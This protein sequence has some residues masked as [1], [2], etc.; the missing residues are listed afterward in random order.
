V[1]GCTVNPQDMVAKAFL[2]TTASLQLS[3]LD[4][5]FRRC[6]Q[7]AFHEHIVSY[8]TEVSGW[9]PMIRNDGPWCVGCKQ[10]VKHDTVQMTEADIRRIC[11]DTESTYVLFHDQKA[12]QAEPW[13]FRP[14][15][16]G[17]AGFIFAELGNPL[18]RVYPGAVR[19]QDV[20]SKTLFQRQ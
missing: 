9:T 18:A 12:P 6:P 11:I 3:K 4:V 19:M 10:N 15:S 7:C 1:T 14:D 17:G 2:L 8:E 20:F 5:K 16:N 13:H